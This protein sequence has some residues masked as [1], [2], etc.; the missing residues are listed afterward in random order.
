MGIL[1]DVSSRLDSWVSA[2]TG[3]GG[4]KDRRNSYKFKGE[5]ALD[6]ETADKL[7]NDNWL[8]A[9]IC[10][11]Y[12]EEALAEGIKITV[13]IKGEDRRS[14]GAKGPEDETKVQARLDELNALE[15]ITEAATFGRAHGDAFVLLGVDDGLTLE[16]PLDVERVRALKY[17]ELIDRRHMTVLKRYAD[18]MLPNYDE[19]ELFT[20]NPGGNSTTT[21][22]VIHESRLLKFRGA[23]VSRRAYRA[24]ANWHYSVLHRVHATIRDFDVSWDAASNMLQTASVGLYGVNDLLGILTSEGGGELLEKRM[25]AI[26]MG[27]SV[28]NSQIF[29]KELESFEYASQSFAGV[30]DMLDR[31]TV[32]V[33]AS[34]ACPVT[35]LFGQAPAGLNATGEQ[36][37]KTWARTLGSYRAKELKPQLEILVG[38]LLAE[39]GSKPESWGIEFTPIDQPTEI[40]QAQLRKTVAETDAIEIS[41]QILTPEEVAVNRHGAE[42]WSADTSI[43]LTLREEI[44]EA[45]PDE[46][47]DSGDQ[48]TIGAR[49]TAVLDIIGQVRDEQIPRETGIQLLINPCG[50]SAEQAEITMGEVGNGFV[51]KPAPGMGPDGLPLDPNAP[52]GADAEA[53]GLEAQA[54]AALGE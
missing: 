26:A 49:V 17:L 33:S 6:V 50:M 13:S 24:N 7:Y 35:V 46:Q 37:R 12:P 34:V 47:P 29:D 4:L 38:V 25:H 22:V 30:P 23:R 8:A 43:D 48:G 20:H 21:G 32:R 40:E 14:E 54:A 9:R 51:P 15:I 18:A 45:D 27:R 36:D 1:R 2:V 5:P 31:L 10:D 52:P 28:S 44:L 3:L 16:Q 42:G 39:L 53:D 19:A 41:A 11:I